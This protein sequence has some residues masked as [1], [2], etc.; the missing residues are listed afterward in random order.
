MKPI[1]AK[2]V[3]SYN[4][5]TAPM[6]RLITVLNKYFDVDVLRGYEAIFCY[7][8]NKNSEPVLIFE[9][10]KENGNLSMSYLGVKDTFE[11]KNHN[12]F[13]KIIQTLAIKYGFNPN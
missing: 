12:E 11:L 1:N 9:V 13:E 3:H 4:N 5:R 6:L 8:K 10:E 7:E 2:D